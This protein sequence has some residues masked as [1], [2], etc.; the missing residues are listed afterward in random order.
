[1]RHPQKSLKRFLLDCLQNPDPDLAGPDKGALKSLGDAMG[2]CLDS[3]KYL[4][5][6]KYIT[7]EMAAL[8]AEAQRLFGLRRSLKIKDPEGTSALCADLKIDD[9]SPLEDEIANL[10]HELTNLIE[11][12]NEDVVELHFL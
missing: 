10:P 12:V 4:D 1:M 2:F 8:R 11:M 7:A 3:D 5:V 6:K 9:T